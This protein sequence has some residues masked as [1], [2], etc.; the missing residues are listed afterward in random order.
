MNSKVYLY[1]FSSKI[2]PRLEKADNKYRLCNELIVMCH[3]SH[4]I[5][6]I[7]FVIRMYTANYPYSL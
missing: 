1:Y 4:S 6:A 3:H 5:V 2:H 7:G